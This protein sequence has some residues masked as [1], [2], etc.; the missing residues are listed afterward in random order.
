LVPPLALLAFSLLA[1]AASGVVHAD[2]HEVPA[3]GSGAQSRANKESDAADAEDAIG[4]QKTTDLSITVLNKVTGRPVPGAKVIIRPVP[5]STNFDPRTDTTT[6][7]GGCKA[8]KLPAGKVK[9]V[10]TAA[11]MESFRKE[12]V[13]NGASQSIRIELTP[14]GHDTAGDEEDPGGS[15]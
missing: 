7:D 11:R 12:Y 6:D 8:K 5:G 2:Q 3:A 15:G 1:L 14:V 10:V 13:V 9:V 4:A